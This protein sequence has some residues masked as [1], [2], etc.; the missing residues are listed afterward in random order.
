MSWDDED[1][2]P[3]VAA[4]AKNKF[5]DEEE[6]VAE[7]WEKALEDDKPKPAAVP[8]QPEPKAAA[9]P[10][11]AAPKSKAKAKAESKKKEDEEEDADI[12]PVEKKLRDQKRIEREDQRIADD[13]FAGCSRPNEAFNAADDLKA[14]KEAKA[15]KAAAVA[16]NKGAARDPW[17]DLKFTNEKDL[18][19][20]AA[21]L[22]QKISD[23]PVKSAGFY[24][25]A[26]QLLKDINNKLEQKDLKNLIVK[27]QAYDKGKTEQATLKVASKKKP[28]DT[29]GK[30]FQDEY[31]MMYGEVKEEEDDDYYADYM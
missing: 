8:A 4:V 7:D 10:F 20:F 2:V 5:A 6:D 12:D 17:D 13:L 25:F 28:N 23:S 27:M 30:N 11:A 3:P 9:A 16:A 31:E 14:E 19:S 18:L 26:D 29:P 22:T 15:K 1:Y 21:K 24:K